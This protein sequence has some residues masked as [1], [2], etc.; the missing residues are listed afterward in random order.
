MD[1]EKQNIHT[2]GFTDLNICYKCGVLCDD[3]GFENLWIVI[4]STHPIFFVSIEVIIFLCCM[5]PEFFV[6]VVL[7][8]LV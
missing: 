1:F 5:N 8:L 6:R 2:G 7:I 4:F 3:L